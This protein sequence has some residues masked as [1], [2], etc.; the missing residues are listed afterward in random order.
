M[1]LVN[2]FLRLN[3]YLLVF[4]I[5]ERLIDWGFRRQFGRFCDFWYD[6]LSGLNLIGALDCDP[7]GGAPLGVFRGVGPHFVELLE[8]DWMILI[9]K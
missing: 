8:T 3:C 4:E 6:D 5:K 7:R 2:I 1:L 9:V